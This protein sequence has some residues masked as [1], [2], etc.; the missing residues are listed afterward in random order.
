MAMS[1][2]ADA[3]GPR[4][5]G[6]P[7]TRA[8]WRPSALQ[9]VIALTVAGG[10]LRFATL[11]VQSIWGD[12]SISL[13]LI[14]RSFG[15]MISQLSSS[16]STPPLYYSLAWVWTRIFGTGP[17]GLR[18]LSAVAGTIT[19]P[20]VW[21]C[22]REVSDRV[23]G[24]AA[25]LAVVSPAMYYYSQEAR[26]YGLLIMFSAAAF[27]FFERAMARRDGRSV[28]WWG[29]FS[30]LA[31]LT[32]YFAAFLFI[33]EALILWRR[34]GWRRL[35]WPVGAVAV[36]AIALA[37]LAADQRKSGKASW[38][39]ES[40]LV[41]RVGETG[42]QFLVGL[43]SPGQL[44]TA[45]LSTLLALGAIWLVVTRAR[46]SERD[47]ARDAAIVAVVGVGIP[48]VLAAGHLI[49]VFDGRNVI[50][51]WIPF[52]VLI[53][54]GLGC[55]GAGR[56]GPALGGGLCAIGLGVII[57]TNLL[58]GYQRDDWRGAA[59]TLPAPLQPRVIVAERFGGSPLAVYLGPQ[60]KT[61]ATTVIAREIAFPV[62]R[63]RHTFGEPS[64]PYAPLQPPRGFRLA[65]ARKTEAFAVTRFVAPAPTPVSARELIRLSG[66]PNSELLVGR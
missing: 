1:A 4:A 21:A 51:A 50:A 47:R 27:L 60:H 44:A 46:G 45:A 52:A 36:V 41:N 66:D 33:P 64:A 14:H 30:V 62:L 59:Q 15:S 57:A 19:I 16:E 17:I 53:A 7:E 54:I 65:S 25:A 55:A 58:P 22:G 35:V 37:P 39:E 6:A 10:V 5:A 63:E 49:D 18:T 61:A 12:E 43:Y 31:L 40:S 28:A 20:L 11:D 9:V 13:A 23:A 38:I 3:P 34:M 48:L 42:K 26:A 8:G 32:H 56:I 24:W 2:R 29:V